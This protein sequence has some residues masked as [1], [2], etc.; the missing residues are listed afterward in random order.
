MFKKII[1][2]L[3]LAFTLTTNYYLLSTSEAAVPRLIN[4]QGRLANSSGSPVAD[5]S[6][7]VIFKI[8]ESE[9]GG[10]PVWQGTYQVT[11]TKG[12]FNVLLGETNDS[13]F[14]FA[15]LTFDKPYYL[16]I[17]VGD[18]VMTPRQKIVSAAY[19]IRAEKAGQ[20]DT[21]DKTIAVETRASD[22][23]SPVNGQIWLIN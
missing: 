2:I 10:A 19:S 23:A 18:E 12:V 16:E 1:F 20:A 11:T 22:P 7:S 4:Y 15:N 21:S 17:K 9:S 13:G 3:L 8:F 6:Y 14:N 5:G